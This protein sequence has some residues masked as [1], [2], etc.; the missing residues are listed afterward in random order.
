MT[1][2]KKLLVLMLIIYVSP[3]FAQ[4]NISAF[5]YQGELI[6]TGTPANGEY[7]FLFTAFDAPVNG[8][9][10]SVFSANNIQ[11][12]NGLFAIP[13]VDFSLTEIVNNE[14]LWMTIEIKKSS[15]PVSSFETLEENQKLQTVPYATMAHFAS[16]A[17]FAVH[18]SWAN[19]ATSLIINGSSTNDILAY[20]GNSWVP[21]N[22]PW[23]HQ[24]NV[25]STADSSTPY[26]ISFGDTAPNSNVEFTVK[27]DETGILSQFI[28]G[29]GLYNEYIE[30]GLAKGYIGSVQDGTITG[31]TTD[32]FEL[33][34]SG[35]N[36]TGNVH[37]TIN[38]IPRL[39]VRNNGSVGI[40]NSEPTGRLQV[41]SNALFVSNGNKVGVGTPIPT[42]KFQVNS[43]SNQSEALT[44]KI[45]NQTKLKVH[46]NGGVAIGKD[47]TPPTEGLYV[48]GDIK[49]NSASNGML[50]YMAR[51]RC[52]DTGSSVTS[53]HN[54]VNNGSITVNDLGT[55][56]SCAVNF[57]TDIN[58]R[59]WQITAVSANGNHNANCHT[60]FANN[61]FICQR[62]LSGSFNNGDIMILVY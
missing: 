53:F 11:V 37:L 43:A 45:D 21:Q 40:G 6:D 55:A 3:T 13:Q 36:Q 48:H 17:S 47:T 62:T 20:D 41:G 57:P 52:L 35:F 16:E 22:N 49:Q 61:Q 54:G 58:Q 50:K 27:S 25:L 32:D 24:G 26:Q 15:D 51:V 31:T 28:G 60:V 19:E 29:D 8:S 2:I 44:V 42:A 46:S 23:H 59:Y 39:T 1:F 30:N 10:V 34:T 33:G 7:D 12:S 4:V 14:E 5:N 9:Q 56:G 18:A 38:A